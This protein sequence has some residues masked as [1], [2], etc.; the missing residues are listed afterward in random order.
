MTFIFKQNFLTS[1]FCLQNMHI[2]EAGNGRTVKRTWV[3]H[4][5]HILCKRCEFCELILF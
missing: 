1:L 3:F 2:N 5:V 4:P